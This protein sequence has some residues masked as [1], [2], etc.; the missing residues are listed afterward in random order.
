MANYRAFKFFLDR[1]QENLE[2]FQTNMSRSLAYS[3]ILAAIEELKAHPENMTSAG[4]QVF[5][6]I[7][8]YY[9]PDEEDVENLPKGLICKEVVLTVAVDPN[10]EYEYCIK[11][12]FFGD[13]EFPESYVNEYKTEEVKNGRAKIKALS[14]KLEN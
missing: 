6:P 13:F 1:F 3:E 12:G 9:E 5:R 10:Q 11:K 8:T 4:E 14:F 7:G 2:I